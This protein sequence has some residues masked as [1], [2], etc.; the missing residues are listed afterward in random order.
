MRET[1][2]QKIER[3]E[4]QNKEKDNELKSLRKEL[5]ETLKVAKNTIQSDYDTKIQSLQETI[6]SLEKRNQSLLD[7]NQEL[8]ESNSELL[9]RIEIY[10]KIVTYPT[11]KQYLQKYKDEKSFEMSNLRLHR[12]N[13][14]C[15]INGLWSNKYGIPF[16]NYKNLIITI[17]PHTGKELNSV[18]INDIHDL[19][20]YNP[21]YQEYMGMMEGIIEKNPPSYFQYYDHGMNIA[22]DLGKELYDKLYSDYN[23]DRFS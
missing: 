13:Y 9:K 11:Y 1:K 10:E 7:Y 4:R 16:F 22:Y 15:F 19:I 17:N 23:F 20:K 12:N 8:V 5:K 3:L 6:K 2:I 21:L 18:Q 14:E